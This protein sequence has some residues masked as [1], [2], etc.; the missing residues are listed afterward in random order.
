MIVGIRALMVKDNG[1]QA[2]N[3][4]Y[5]NNST[6]TNS[7]EQDLI[8]LDLS[9]TTIKKTLEYIRNTIDKNIPIRIH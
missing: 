1:I 2:L 7:I 5:N 3:E 8:D 6:D 4:R 9:N